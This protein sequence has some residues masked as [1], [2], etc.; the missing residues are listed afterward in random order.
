MSDILGKQDPGARLIAATEAERD[1]SGQGGK[2]AG[3]R[4]RQRTEPRGS[5]ASRPPPP[6][7]GRK[8]PESYTRRQRLS[9]PKGPL[10][11]G[12]RASEDPYRLHP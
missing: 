7:Q 12:G 3:V 5:P 10:H 8:P 6:E 1:H 11:R 9:Q 4:C 2:D